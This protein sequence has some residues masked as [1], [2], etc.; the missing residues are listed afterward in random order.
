MQARF[1]IEGE[2]FVDPENAVLV[3]QA[4]PNYLA[5]AVCDE[6]GSRLGEL[7]WFTIEGDEHSNLLSSME[8]FKRNY[9]RKII[10]F[11]FPEYAL[12]PL[13]LN[14]GDPSALLH[15]A[16][17]NA[18]DH[19][20]TE[21]VNKNISLSYTVP[22]K[23]LNQSIH[24]LPGASY[25]HLQTIRITEAFNDRTSCFLEVNI[26][27]DRFS[28]IAM[29]KGRLLIAQYYTYRVPEDVLFYLLKIAEVHGL[30][31]TEVQLNI[32][33]LIDADSKLYKLLYD[34]FLN[35]RLMKAG[36]AGEVSMPLPA[37]YFTTFKQA[38][39]CELYPEN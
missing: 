19:I 1:E 5:Y 24:Y 33:G 35:I 26:V 23:L 15:L 38:A 31:Q 6:L 11:D 22:F 8:A 18:Q 17:S 13:Q 3:V 20:L 36:W 16:G 2:H 34:Y 39:I 30:P 4:G 21:I 32:S 37:H 25:W 28:V 14:G 9:Q 7:K 12:L 10:T 29:E 27:D